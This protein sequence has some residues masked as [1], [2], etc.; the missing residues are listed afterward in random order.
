MIVGHIGGGIVGAGYQIEKSLRLRASASAFLSRTYAS[1]ASWT[2]S[3]FV[4][5]GTLGRITPILE[6]ALQFNANDTLTA[7]GVTT[8]AVFRDPTAHYHIVLSSAGLWVNGV[9]LG[10]PTTTVRTNSRIGYDGTNYADVYLSEWNFIDSS[11]LSATSFGEFNSDGVWVPKKYTG[12]YAGA[13]YYLPFSD[14]SS[15][16]NLTADQ[17]GNGNNWTANSVSLTAGTGY[18]WMEDTPT[19]VFPTFNSLDYGNAAANFVWGGLGATLG[20]ASIGRLAWSTIP[21]NKGKWYVEFQIGT[22]STNSMLCGIIPQSSA[23]IVRNNGNT[24]V[25]S[26][27]GEYGF[28]RVTASIPSNSATLISN[29]LASTG[30]SLPVSGDT[31]GLAFDADVGSLQIYLNGVLQSVS[32]FGSIPTGTYFFAASA[33]N[34]TWFV[35]FGQRPFAYTPPTG[36]KALCTKNLPPVAITNPRKHFDI[37]LD[38]GANIKTATEALFPANFFEWI[39]DRANSNN[40]QLIDIVR[41]ASAVLQSNTTAAET[42][43]S[44]PAGSSVGWVWKAGGAPV[45]NNA[46][47]IQSQVSANVLAGFSI[48]TYTGTRVNATV[49]HGLGVAPKLVIV[50]GRS[51]ATGWA[52]WHAALLG[53]EYLNLHL[54]DAKATAASL[55]NNT[56]PNSTVFALG[57]NGSGNSSGATYVAYCFAEVPGFSKI[58]SYT[59]NGSADGPFVWCGFRPRWILIKRIDSTGDWVIHDAARSPINTNIRND[60]FANLSAVEATDTYPVD[61]LANGFKVRNTGTGYNINGGT[62][63]FYAIAEQPFNAPSNAR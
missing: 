16:A 21:V 43:Y 35:N 49:G 25:G 39:K 46:G 15:L 7:F 59:G 51:L 37:V 38:T 17:S 33:A 29:V 41:G 23:Q 27:P 30:L 13:G 18:D 6:G 58:G 14:G 4:K 32:G 1:A 11:S 45:V 42:V 24:Y 52:T 62:Y 28:G 50:R 2:L 31:I 55:W 54:T 40:H 20:S 44:A 19:N 57:S 34:T 63:I 36:F 9:S 53:T 60:L 61:I 8:T 47:S 5:R 12:L 48:V 22:V 3:C 56:I 10:E 26:L